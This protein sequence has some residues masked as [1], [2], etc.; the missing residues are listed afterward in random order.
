MAI[1]NAM[2]FKKYDNFIVKKVDKSEY[3]VEYIAQHVKF[4]G[5][6]GGADTV[7]E[8]LKI[9]NE[10]LEMYLEVLNKQEESKWQKNN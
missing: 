10:A 8:A 5:I 1:T 4:K 9:A 7:D 3:S 2:K 6:T